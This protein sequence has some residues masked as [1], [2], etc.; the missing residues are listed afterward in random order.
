LPPNYCSLAGTA[1]FIAPPT[2]TTTSTTTSTTKLPP[3]TTTSTTTST[4]TLPPITSYNT[5]LFQSSNLV[6]ICSGQA[7]AGLF[8][9]DT[10]E[11]NWASGI[12]TDMYRNEPAPIGCYSEGIEGYRCWDGN[13]L[14]P[15]FSCPTGGGGGGCFVAGTEILLSDNTVK[16]IENL[17]VGDQLAS[18]NIKGLPLYSDN[19]NMLSIW[20]TSDIQGDYT[21]AAITN[22]KPFNTN[23]IINI[24]G[25]LQ[26]TP[27]HRHLIKAGDIWSFIEAKD[28][29]IG[30]ILR[31]YNN[32]EILVET[33]SEEVGNFTAYTLD[34]ENT[35]LFYA[36][37]ILTHNY[38]EISGEF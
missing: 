13:T 4:T 24:N 32:E 25:L 15:Q 30:D 20:N 5:F 14:G 18:Y 22:I 1:E 6:D 35:D 38:K 31:N 27:N 16:L 28:V 37:N 29:K 9:I 3:T 26:T 10:P 7:F 17:Q 2:T 11:W 19:Q 23:K 21:A 34:V 12:Y 36:N 33:V 8:Y